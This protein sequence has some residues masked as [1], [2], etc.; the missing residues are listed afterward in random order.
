MVHRSAAA[1]RAAALAAAAAVL[2]AGLMAADPLGAPLAASAAEAAPGVLTISA[3][4]PRIAPGD[5]AFI[6]VHRSGGADGVVDVDVDSQALP[7]ELASVIA[8]IDTRVTFLDHDT[9]DKVIPIVFLGD[10]PGDLPVGGGDAPSGGDVPPVGDVP[11]SDPMDAPGLGRGSAGA[12]TSVSADRAVSRAIA[13]AEA[14]SAPFTVS[15]SAPTG[16]GV[17]GTPSTVS[18]LVATP[19]TTTPVDGGSDSGGSSTGGTT[20]PGSTAPGSST[21]NSTG[22]TSPVGGDRSLAD[23]GAHAMLPVIGATLAAI[24]GLAAVL[25]VRRRRR[26]EST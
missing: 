1:R 3:S 2:V 18:V 26:P 23:T 15:L 7:A 6:S 5:R 8:P 16:G 20:T 13:A 17:L 25:F 12:A 4:S 22:T 9:A 11:P 10:V 14:G 24:L 21:R 19:P